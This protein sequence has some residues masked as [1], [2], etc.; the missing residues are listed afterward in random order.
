MKIVEK[1]QKRIQEGKKNNK[2]F[3]L[4]EL[5]I[6]IAIM[7]ILIGIVGMN[8]LPQIENARQSKD[9]QVLSAYLTESVE[10]VTQNAS[11]CL[12][13]SYRI[14]ITNSK[15]ECTAT[16]TTVSGDTG[17][18]AIEATFKELSGIDKL[19][20]FESTAGKAITQITIDLN[21]STTSASGNDIA[22]LTLTGTGTDK[23]VDSHGLSSK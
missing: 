15:V 22:V 14:V 19:P 6:V 2:G 13:S 8:V 21:L 7:A 9:L 10:A 1:L 5:I 16:G 4:V 11:R 3:S 17:H 12:G 20:T 18:E 23:L